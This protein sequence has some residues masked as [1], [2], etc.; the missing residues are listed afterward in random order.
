MGFREEDR[1]LMKNLYVLK[2]MEQKKLIKEFLNKG[3]RLWGLLNKAARK[4]HDSC[5]HEVAALK[6]YRIFLVFLLRNIHTKTGYYKKE[7]SHLFAN[8]LSCNTIKYY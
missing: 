6:A 4:W 7:I 8:F 1:I 2:V 3:W 5:Q